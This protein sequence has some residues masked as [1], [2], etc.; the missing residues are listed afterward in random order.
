MSIGTDMEI[1]QG[2]SDSR[3]IETIF[4][5]TLL[6]EGHVSMSANVANDQLSD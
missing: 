4:T 3:V 2:G 5:T 6:R 1:S